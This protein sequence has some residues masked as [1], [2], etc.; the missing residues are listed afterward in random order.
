MDIVHLMETSTEPLQ[1]R[2]SHSYAEIEQTITLDHSE[3]FSV[4]QE[5]LSTA[6]HKQSEEQA[7]SKES[8]SSDHPPIVSEE[9]ISVGYSTFQDSIPKTEADS[10]TTVL[11]PQTH[12]EQVQQDFSGKMQDL[13]ED[14]QEYFVTTPGTEGSETHKATAEPGSPSKTPEEISTP[15]EEERQYL[16]TPTS[17]ERGGSPIVQEPEELP[18]PREEG[19]PRKTSLVIVESADDQ[20]QMVERLDGDATFDKGDD[21]PD[22]PPETVTEEE[23]IDEHGHTVVKKVT[24][25]IIR[26]YVSSDGTEKEEITMQGMPQ[27]PVTIEE[28]DGYSKVIKR[29]VLKSDIEQSEVTLSEPSILS[30][31]SQFQAEPVEGRRV[32]K[33]IKTTMVRGERMEKHLGDSSLATDLPSAKDDFEEDNHE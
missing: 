3:G 10:A 23:Y 22:I 18:E 15:P 12:K 13:P 17:S 30:S 25:K 20:A 4:L 11:S 24:R 8:E 7:F 31:T 29:V 6:Q 32:S 14:K 5:E 2:I 21:M 26:R 16:Q 1:E 19:S 27:E 9:D 28:G 33:V